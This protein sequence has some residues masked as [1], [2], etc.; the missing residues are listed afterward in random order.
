MATNLNMFKLFPLRPA[1]GRASAY[2]GNF[3]LKFKLQQLACALSGLRA[4]TGKLQ[5][6]ATPSC[7]GWL[8]LSAVQHSSIVLL[9]CDAGGGTGMWDESTESYPHAVPPQ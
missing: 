4:V 1:P 6:I 2:Y 5:R 7:I 9:H 8:A 3:N